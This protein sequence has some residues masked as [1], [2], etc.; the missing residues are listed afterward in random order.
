MAQHRLSCASRGVRHIRV[1]IALN[2]EHGNRYCVSTRL[3]VSIVSADLGSGAWV[4]ETRTRK[5]QACSD[6]RSPYSIR[7]PAIARHSLFRVAPS[8]AF[9]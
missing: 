9:S 3:L 1:N 2:R 6:Q 5:T 4:L 8:K 7:L